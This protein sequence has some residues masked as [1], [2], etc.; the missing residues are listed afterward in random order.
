MASTFSRPISGI[1]LVA[2][3]GLWAFQQPLATYSW[4]D[5]ASDS[6][7]VVTRIKEP[8]G[9]T[10]VP[11]AD[12]SFGSWLRRF[13]LKKGKPEV[14]L[15]DGSLKSNQRAHFAVLDIDQGTKDLQQCADAVIRLRAE[16]LY[17]QKKFDNISFHFTN[18]FPFAYKRWMEGSRVKVDGN[19]TSWTN[20]ARV[21][22]DASYKTFRSYLN[23]AFSYCGTL[24]LSKEL[25]S[26]ANV[27]DIKPG[28]VFIR[29]GS[30]G[31][32]VI[33]MDVAANGEGKKVFL[34]AQSYMPAQEMHIL[35]NPVNA[36][37]SPWFP[38]DFGSDLITPEWT[39]NRIELKTW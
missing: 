20:P 13:P 30:P 31:H 19:R 17:G 6:E 18:D 37:L 8:E 3:I 23:M 5:T 4:L 15:F 22:N 25:K 9:Y 10:R 7:R 33:V 36:Q 24:S 32:A 1:L 26:V 14:H 12:N 39:F 28:D 16:Y 11:V 21:S 35:K 27:K 38:E 29:G 2:A 34:L